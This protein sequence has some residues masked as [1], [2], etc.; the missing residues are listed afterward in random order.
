MFSLGTENPGKPHALS[1]L[2]QLCIYLLSISPT[3]WP[4]M[5]SC[6]ESRTLHSD[7]AGACSVA[8]TTRRRQCGL[9]ESPE[10]EDAPGGD[11]RVHCPSPL[12]D[13]RVHCTRSGERPRHCPEEGL[14]KLSLM[15]W[16]LAIKDSKGTSLGARDAFQSPPTITCCESA[17]HR[18]ITRCI[19][20]RTA[21]WG[22]LSL[23]W[24]WCILPSSTA[25]CPSGSR[26]RT[27]AKSSGA[28]SARGANSLLISSKDAR[29]AIFMCTG[30]TMSILPPDLAFLLAKRQSAGKCL[31]ISARMVCSWLAGTC[32]SWRSTATGRTAR[33]GAS[34]G[35]EL[36]RPTGPTFS[37]T[38]FPRVRARWSS[39]SSHG[40]SGSAFGEGARTGIESRRGG[41]TCGDEGACSDGAVRAG[42]GALEGSLLDRLVVACPLRHAAGARGD[43]AGRRCGGGALSDRAGLRSC[44][45]WVGGC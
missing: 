36:A 10:G 18:A 13:V 3:Y 41:R 44:R 22:M 37:E 8:D 14:G 16:V 15:T 6:V 19:R 33:I 20:E 42:G 40:T 12:H 24:Y 7:S 31:C 23:A 39:A 2:F 30:V 4:L 34:A 1:G 5:H 32:A 21:A 35:N 11:R 43:R 45:V 27:R 26:I 28:C 29:E 9:N 17:P 38:I 25:A